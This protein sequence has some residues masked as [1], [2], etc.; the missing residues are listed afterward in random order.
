MLGPVWRIWARD[1]GTFMKRAV[2]IMA[3]LVGLI[4]LAPLFAVVAI[5]IKADSP[6]TVFFRQER[7]GKGF[8][9]FWIYKFRTMVKDPSLTGRLL[10]AGHDPRITNVGRILRHTKI[11]ELPQLLNV[12]RGDMSLVGPL[13]PEVRQYVELFKKRYESIL[14]MRPGI[15]DL[16]SLKRPNEQAILAGFENPEEEYIQRLLP[17]K[18]RL[19]EE[20]LRQCSVVYDLTLIVKTLLVL[21]L[22]KNPWAEETFV[23]RRVSF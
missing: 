20:Y 11:D 1:R 21:I 14:T 10:T 19:G 9:P 7:M 15:T 23:R 13:R 4:V 22:K 8:R 5:L 16:A 3:A 18:L 6:G 2:D 12:L 17:E